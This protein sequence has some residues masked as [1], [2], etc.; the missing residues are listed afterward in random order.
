[1]T[2]SFYK[3]L[4]RDQIRVNIPMKAGEI[5]DCFFLGP[6]LVSISPCWRK[7]KTTSTEYTTSTNEVV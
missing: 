1:M 6:G 5:F 3:G 7:C 4:T 2:I